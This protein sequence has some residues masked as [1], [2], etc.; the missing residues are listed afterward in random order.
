MKKLFTILLLMSFTWNV[1]AFSYEDIENSLLNP[2][3]WSNWN[4]AHKVFLWQIW[5]YKDNNWVE[6]FTG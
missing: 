5:V 4:V 6:I 3:A 2:I 1:S